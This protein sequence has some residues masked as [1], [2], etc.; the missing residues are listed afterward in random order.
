MSL[1]STELSDRVVPVVYL[2]HISG[3]TTT[4]AAVASAAGQTVHLP[5]KAANTSPAFY[6]TIP[7]SKES[8]ATRRLL[9]TRN[10]L[11]E[12]SCGAMHTSRDP[13]IS[14]TQSD[15]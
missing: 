3:N 11:S 15:N 12:G 9:T 5:N 1:S 2:V 14:K 10:F 4:V 8:L 6:R 7:A 13:T